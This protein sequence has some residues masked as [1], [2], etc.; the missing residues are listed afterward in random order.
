MANLMEIARDMVHWQR[1]MEQGGDVEDA[2]IWRTPEIARQDLQENW[3]SDA[4][5]WELDPED[6]ETRDKLWDMVVAEYFGRA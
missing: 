2:K 3:E 4:G 6:T 5:C 1:V